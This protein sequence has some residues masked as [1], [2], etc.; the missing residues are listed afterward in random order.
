MRKLRD[1]KVDAIVCASPMGLKSELAKNDFANRISQI[2]EESVVIDVIIAGHTHKN[3]GNQKVSGVPYTQDN[4][5]GIHRGRTD[6]VFSKSKH[7]LEFVN[8]AT[9]LLDSSISQDPM[10]LSASA[11]QRD[12]S[13]KE[14]TPEIGGLK[15]TLSN[16]AEP[17]KAAE[18]LLL[19]TRA[20]RLALEK[21]K[22]NVDGVLHGSFYE[23]DIQASPKTIADAWKIVP[24][25][26]FLSTA[27]LTRAKLITVLEECLNA[28][29][30]SH[31]LDGFMVGVT[32]E[33]KKMVVQ[34]VTLPDSKPLDQN[35]R[36]RIAL[37]S[38]DSQSG[39][40]RFPKLHE[41]TTAPKSKSEVF[42]VQ[43]REALIEYFTEK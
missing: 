29:L 20:L 28:A 39:G 21:R 30:S 19:L 2:A 24:C 43:S 1:E 26:N 33:G 36:C 14:L 16:E 13:D 6:L 22:V 32:S 10:I 37:N 8:V 23:I 34:D 5:Y 27:G 7:R 11:K 18:S 41:I 12:S 17:G 3:L 38:F 9:K 35:V 40:Q 25:E 31:P 42:D 4:Y 15:E